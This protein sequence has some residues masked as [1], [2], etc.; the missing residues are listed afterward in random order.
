MT[1]TIVSPYDIFST[2]ENLEVSGVE[3]AIGQMFFTLARAGGQN[4]KFKKAAQAKF[5]PYEFAI[6]NDALSER[7]AQELVVDV[8]VDTVLLGWRNVYGRDKVLIPY[9]K[10]AAIKLLLDLPDLFLRLQ[11]EA[12]T[13][14]NFRKKGIEE[15]AKN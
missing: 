9:S 13:M 15:V 10:E 2:E 3:V 7:Q 5:K 14:S 4:M 1:E 8:F 11:N 12:S 6:A